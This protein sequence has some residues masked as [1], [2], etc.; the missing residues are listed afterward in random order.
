MHHQNL[1]GKS[2]IVLMALTLALAPATNAEDKP[3]PVYILAG[4]SNMVGIGTF[5]GGS[6]GWE[7]EFSGLAL[8]NY[9]GEPDL[10]TDYDN[11]KPSKVIEYEN[12][13]AAKKER[14]P[15]EGTNIL[16]GF[17]TMPETGIYEF[18]SGYGGSA[19]NVTIIDGKEA[20][21]QDLNQKE[22]TITPIKLEAGKKVPFK[23]TYLRNDGPTTGWLSRI[24]L[25]GTLHTLV[26]EEGKFKYLTDGEGNFV[27]RDDVWYRGVVTAKGNQWLNYG[28]GASDTSI[29]PELGFGH[30]VGDF[31][32]EPVILLKT[33]QGNRSLGWDFLPPG[34]ERFEFTEE[35]GTVW[36]YAGYKDTSPRWKKGEEPE[37]VPWYGGKQY[38][39]CFDAAKEVLAN[40][41]KEFPQWAGRGYEI[42]GFGWWQG[43][44]DGGQQGKEKAGALATRYEHNLAHLIRTLRKEFNAPDAPFVVAT[45]GFEGGEGWEPGSSAMTIFNAQM[46]VSDPEKHPDFK[47]TVASVDTRPFFRPADQSPRDQ[48]FHYHGNA[49]TYMLVGEGMGEAMVK[50]KKQG[51]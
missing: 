41:D 31:H 49:E 28:C 42:A 20:Y 12:F 40:F 35:D 16:R 19:H 5:K 27:P 30:K 4:Q 2:I 29:G 25:P 32:D 11:K 48:G 47:G 44:K 8:S 3:I 7:N 18:K 10:E 36:V 6:R 17:I 9:S 45:C 13:I 1:L 37:E 51:K 38:D 43:H 34:S 39:E 14:M 33:S 15:E 22:P 50:L 21:R 24:D 46:A 26:Q 23:I